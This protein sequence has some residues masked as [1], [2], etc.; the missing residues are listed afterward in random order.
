MMHSFHVKNFRGFRDLKIE[1][2]KRVNLIAGMNNVGKTALLE[3]VFLHLG[4]DNPELGLRINVMRGID[5]FK[6]DIEE[7]WGNLFHNFD[8]NDAIELSSLDEKGHSRKLTISLSAQESQRLLSASRNGKSKLPRTMGSV[9]TA[10]NDIE[11]RMQ[12]QDRKGKPYLTRL[13]VVDDGTRRS[14][15]VKRE[16][17]VV[18]IPGVL[19]TTRA[20][21][22]REDAERFSK[23]EATGRGGQ[24]LSVL[25]LL[26]VRLSKLALLVA[27][28]EPA[29]HGDVG[30]G[31]LLPLPLL[32]EGIARLLS[33]VLAIANTPNGVVLIDE[34]ETGFHHTVLKNVW[35]AIGQAASQSNTQIIATTHNRECIQAA[36][37]AFA[38]MEAYDFALHRLDRIGEDIEAVSYDKESLAAAMR[39]ELEV[40]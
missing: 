7:A 33:I 20:R 27:G 34:I 23:L 8:T 28:T 14:F 39:A 5:Q 25:Q 29:I 22:L 11:L 35:T 17:H 9:T 1:N 18:P 26:E 40:R 37:D 6:M 21:F 30:V 15:Q 10:G 36:H 24:L 32:G 19:L 12:Y 31:R 3:A 13:F 38:E 16:H 2:L 4:P